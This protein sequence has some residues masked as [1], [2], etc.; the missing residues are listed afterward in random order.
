MN[1]TLFLY[2]FKEMI[3]YFLVCFLFFFIIFFVN[4]IL[5]MAEDILSKKAPLKDVLLLI[6]FALPSIIATSAPFAALVGTL[7]GLGR[8]VS[9]REVLSM[10]ALGIPVY[11]IFLPVL[12]AGIVISAVSFYTNDSLLPAGTIEFTKLYR[13]ILTSTPAL[14]LESNTI[15]RNQN[16]ILVTGTISEKKIDSL[17]VIDTSSTGAKRIV[18]AADASILEPDNA[19]ILMTLSMKNPAVLSIDRKDRNT[20]DFLRASDISYNVLMKNVIPTYSSTIA[21]REM[22]SRDLYREIQKLKAENNVKSLQ[23]YIMEFNKK[24]SIPFGAFFFVLIAFP[25]ALNAKTNGQNTG[26][27]IGLIIA[28]LY[29]AMLIVGQNLTVRLG[30]NGAFMMWLPNITLAIAALILAARRLVR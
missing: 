25:L 19:Q 21:P 30:L 12:C 3:L 9:D 15:K 6:F 26:F 10:N 8:M 11:L 1:K 22:S 24:F 5:L 4:Q 17:L 27:I 14:E 29:W 18:S 28:V 23:S 7:M 2:I 13:S 16:A 20:F